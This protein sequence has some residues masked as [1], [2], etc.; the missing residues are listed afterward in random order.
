MSVRMVIMA[1]GTGGHVFPALAVAR[2]LAEQGV[3][4]SWLGTQRGLE[5][6]LVPQAGIAIDFITIGGLR[7]KGLL[8]WL[9]A[10][11]RL[12]RAVAQAIAVLR[13][14]RPAA[15]L[16]MGGF[17]A[18]PGGIGARLLGLPLLVH[19]QNAIA[20]LTNRVLS[21]VARVVMQAFPGA[22]GE[23]AT[24]R[25]TGNPV[26]REITTLPPPASR[27]ADRSGP[28][29]LLVVGGSLG[30][31]ALNQVVPAAL[32]QLPAAIRPQVLHQC[33]Q[34]HLAAATEGYQAAGV[35]AQVVPF[36]D[37]MAAAYAAADL[38]ICRAGALT[39]SELACVGAASLLVPFPFAVDDHQSANGRFLAAAGAAELIQEQALD[40]ARLAHFLTELCADPVA[41]RT[42]LLAMAEAARALARPEAAR[43][44][45]AICL[46]AAGVNP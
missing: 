6:E 26:R 24:L 42:R 22:F 21:R 29:Q 10:P 32:A 17:A 12:T 4:I 44:V 38:V 41:G 28:L 30:A 35:A 46:N 25:T 36:I 39:V 14:R 20:G 45:A 1:G 37:D 9:L 27:F 7:G 13:Q 23:R 40:S 3:E 31:R 19:E 33:G 16:G 2:E 11:L 18:G 15:V 5:A 34:R 8:G 43:E